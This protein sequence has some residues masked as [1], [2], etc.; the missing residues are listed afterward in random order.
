MSKT[1]MGDVGQLEVRLTL[2]GAK[3]PDANQKHDHYAKHWVVLSHPHPKF[4]GT[5]DNKVITTLERTFQSLG[6]G[7][8][9]YNFRG[10]G[11]SDGEYDGGD[12]EQRDLAAI[13]SWLREAHEVEH[14]TLAGFSFGSYVSLKQCSPLKADAICT[15]APAVGMYDFSDIDI[16]VPWVLVQGG[17]DEV[18]SAHEVMDWAMKQFHVPSIYYRRQASHFF[19]RQLVWLKQVILLEY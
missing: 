7:T 2:P 4:G 16:N 5:M 10:V 15:V 3:K 1:V 17:E 11:A 9:A 18:V 12:G 14:L 8:L 6:Y 13:V 19:H